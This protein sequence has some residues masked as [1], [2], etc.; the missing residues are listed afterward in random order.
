MGRIYPSLARIRDVSAAIGGAVAT[1]AFEDGLAGVAEPDSVLE[2]VE[3]T[4]WTPRY[5]SYLD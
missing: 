4:M 5:E 1:V 3:S 2:L